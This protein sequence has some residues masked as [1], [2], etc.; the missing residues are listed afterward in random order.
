MKKNELIQKLNKN[1]IPIEYKQSWIGQGYGYKADVIIDDVDENKVI[2]IPEYGYDEEGIPIINCIY[3]KKDLLNI[4]KN[5]NSLLEF[6]WE[7]LNWQF[8]ET[9]YN[10]LESYS[11]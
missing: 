2:Y 7:T 11:F 4:C 3:T 10:E 5:N 9:L 8:P 6:M 1:C